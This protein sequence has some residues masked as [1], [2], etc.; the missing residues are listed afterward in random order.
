MNADRDLQ[1]R[2][3]VA[4]RLLAHPQLPH[5]QELEALLAA[6]EGGRDV[7]FEIVDL[8]R[9]Q[10][11]ILLWLE[12]ELVGHFTDR[13][14]SPPGGNVGDIPASTRWLCPIEGCSESLPVIREGEDPPSCPRHGRQ[15]VRKKD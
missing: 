3:A 1:V 2:Y 8:F 14:Y 15:M 9:E 4:R 11:N 10:R 12:G 13:D 7:W 6:G 5:R